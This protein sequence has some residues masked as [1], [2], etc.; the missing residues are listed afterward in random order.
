MAVEARDSVFAHTR[1]KY[2]GNTAAITVVTY[3]ELA[4]SYNT[5][6]TILRL[7]VRFSAAAFADSCDK[8]LATSMHDVLMQL[9]EVGRVPDGA[10]RD[11]AVLLLL[12]T[13][14]IAFSLFLALTFATLLLG[15]SPFALLLSLSLL[16]VL[17]LM[18]D[19]E[20]AEPALLGLD[21]CRGELGLNGGER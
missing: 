7:Y 13:M 2:T 18:R 4:Q 5:H 6:D 11:I 16:L 20:E 21:V 8:G 3:A 10:V 17:M 15:A 14:L 19:A 12:L 9:G 1:A